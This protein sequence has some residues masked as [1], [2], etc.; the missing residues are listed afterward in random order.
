MSSNSSRTL[1]SCRSHLYDLKLARLYE[2]EIG[3]SS[4]LHG[5]NRGGI[6]IHRRTLKELIVLM[7]SQNDRSGFGRRVL[8]L[9]GRSATLENLPSRQP[10]WRK[11]FVVIGRVVTLRLRSVLGILAICS[12]GAAQADSHVAPGPIS[13][14]SIGISVSVRPRIHLTTAQVH[15]AAQSVGGARDARGRICV[16]TNMP[17]DRFTVAVEY[18]DTDL[19][20]RKSNGPIAIDAAAKAMCA[21]SSANQSQAA[22]VALALPSAAITSGGLVQLVISP[23]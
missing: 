14:A 20:T 16:A 11:A 8:R 4:S 5:R 10:R 18:V 21:V 9:R 15:T 1:L 2:I 22:A 3:I 13:E 19:V 17:E 6:S 7:V 12:G 23:D